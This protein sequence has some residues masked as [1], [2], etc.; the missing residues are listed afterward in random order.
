M[1]IMFMRNDEDGYNDVDGGTSQFPLYSG[2]YRVLES[3]TR[4]D[5][6][7]EVI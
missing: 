2:L 1:L 4:D 7:T 5:I 6:I 3:M